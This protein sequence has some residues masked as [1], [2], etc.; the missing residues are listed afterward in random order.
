MENLFRIDILM[1]I[2]LPFLAVSGAWFSKQVK[3][4]RDR[5]F[6][7]LPLNAAVTGVLWAVITRTT[8]TPLTAATVIFDTVYALSYFLAF[9][10]LG[11][12][13]TLM[14]GFGVALALVALVLLSL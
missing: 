11:E 6:P 2:L 14:Q 13:V 10:A 7:L 9:A 4:G 5:F 3:L 1:F 8:K 12:P